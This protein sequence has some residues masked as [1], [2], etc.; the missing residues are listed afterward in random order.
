MV[1]KPIVQAVERSID[2]TVRDFQNL[3][4][5]FITESDLQCCLFSHLRDERV[6]SVRCAGH[7]VNLVHSEFPVI[8]ENG[9]VGNR[10]DMVVWDPEFLAGLDEDALNDLWGCGRAEQ[11]RRIPLLV[12][13]EIKHFYG[14]SGYIKKHLSSYSR[15]KRHNDFK[16]LTKGKSRYCYFLGFSDEDVKQHSDAKRYFEK[17][18]DSFR[19]ARQR[20]GRYFRVLCVSRDH[21]DEIRLG[22][23]RY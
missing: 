5:N 11:A 12:A 6:L 3:G 16:K 17:M 23:S 7:D 19:R 9:E 22:F 8:W 10:Y 4:F 21:Y 14:G 20:T 1:I 2:K 15:I 13:I 18:R